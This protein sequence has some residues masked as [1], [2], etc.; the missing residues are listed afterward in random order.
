MRGNQP[1]GRDCDD[2]SHR[3]LTVTLPHAEALFVRARLVNALGAHR[4]SPLFKT[5][6]GWEVII[7]RRCIKQE[8]GERLA[9]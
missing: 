5:E 9:S 3:V 4:V 7:C 8:Y 2:G 6:V 1:P